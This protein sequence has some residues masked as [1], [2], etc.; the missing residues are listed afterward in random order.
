MNKFDFIFSYASKMVK[1]NK[2]KN[3]IIYVV[4]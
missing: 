3:Y 4:K 2:D 1:V